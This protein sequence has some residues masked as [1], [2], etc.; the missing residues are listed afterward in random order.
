MDSSDLDAIREHRTAIVHRPSGWL[1]LI[2]ISCCAACAQSWPCMGQ[3]RQLS[4]PRDV[5]REK[6][7]IEWQRQTIVR[8]HQLRQAGWSV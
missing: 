3:L 4:A 8:Q 6:A 1:A 2:G 7:V 5:E